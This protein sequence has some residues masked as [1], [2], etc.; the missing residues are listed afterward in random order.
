MQ[1][2]V[3]CGNVVKEPLIQY[4]CHAG[5]V[6]HQSGEMSRLRGRDASGGHVLVAVGCILSLVHAVI[7]NKLDLG[8]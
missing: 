8:P 6:T 7:G 1:I 3:Q 2:R 4:Q 5:P